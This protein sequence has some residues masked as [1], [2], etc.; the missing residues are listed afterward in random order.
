VTAAIEYP[1]KTKRVVIGQIVIC[2]GCCCGAV[3][4]GK[5]EVPVDWLK[6]EWR[7]RGLLKN[8]QLTISCCLGPCDLANVVRISGS[9]IEIWLGNISRFE[10]YINLVEWASESKAAGAFLPLPESFDRLRFNPFRPAAE[11]SPSIVDIDGAI[12]YKELH[13]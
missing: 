11:A 1:L 3:N 6:Q 4:R 12:Y 2:S 9:S 13:V 5:P 8:V 10:Q 7:R